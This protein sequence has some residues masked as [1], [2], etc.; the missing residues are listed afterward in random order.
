MSALKENHTISIVSLTIKNTY[1]ME[2]VWDN[3]TILLFDRFINLI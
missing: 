1:H 2:I 3:A